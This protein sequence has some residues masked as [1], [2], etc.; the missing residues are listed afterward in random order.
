[1]GTSEAFKQG[2]RGHTP[3]QLRHQELKLNTL[4]SL[5]LPFYLSTPYRSM[6]IP[7][8]IP[9]PLHPHHH[10]RPIH[11]CAKT[12]NATQYPSPHSPPPPPPRPLTPLPSSPSPTVQ[13]LVR[14]HTPYPSPLLS[15][16]SSYPFLTLNNASSL[17]T[18]FSFV[19]PLKISKEIVEERTELR[20][21]KW[22]KGGE[23]GGLDMG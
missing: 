17:H 18:P 16:P 10:P 7:T 4:P 13:R 23:N 8:T 15:S 6:F 1:M 20:K 21:G 19:S 14:H 9:N 11:Y 22:E 5:P 12:R 2:I 3:C